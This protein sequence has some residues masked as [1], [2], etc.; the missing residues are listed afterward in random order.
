MHNEHWEKSNVQDQ[1]LTQAKQVF[2]QGERLVRRMVVFPPS[3]N[4]DPGSSFGLHW[5]AL[6][7]FLACAVHPVLSSQCLA[8]APWFWKEGELSWSCRLLEQR[9]LP[10]LLPPA[11]SGG[12]LSQQYEP[13]ALPAAGA[14]MWQGNKHR[15][16][17]P[18]LH[19]A[20]AVVSRCIEIPSED[21]AWKNRF[22]AAFQLNLVK[23]GEKS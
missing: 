11:G 18:G 17:V 14:G 5:V 8:M 12:V 7:M 16:K 19:I 2:A 3:R 4:Q 22:A 9:L 20:Q 10:C 6:V 21:G 23:I 13:S 15:G 1:L